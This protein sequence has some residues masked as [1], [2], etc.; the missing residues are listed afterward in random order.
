MDEA[1]DFKIVDRMIAPLEAILHRAQ[2]LR[3]DLLDGQAA[4]YRSSQQEKIEA[5][6]ERIRLLNKVMD[7]VSELHADLGDDQ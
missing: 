7:A 5:L 6:E 1:S 2:D 3:L 4:R